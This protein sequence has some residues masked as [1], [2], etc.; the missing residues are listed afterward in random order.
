MLEDVDPPASPAKKTSRELAG[1][2]R[3][4]KKV[5]QAMKALECAAYV[6]DEDAFE[7]ADDDGDR[8]GDDE[9][10]AVGHHNGK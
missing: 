4:L 8:D 5:E 3:N 10:N 1:T 6:S 2:L 9:E 7:P